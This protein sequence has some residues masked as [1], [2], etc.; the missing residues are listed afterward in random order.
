MNFTPAQLS[1]VATLLSDID[2]SLTVSDYDGIGPIA[3]KLADIEVSD[4]AGYVLGTIKQSPTGV[5]F[6]PNTAPQPLGIKID[7]N[8][9]KKIQNIKGVRQITNEGLKEAKD[10]VDVGGII[11]IPTE[12]L[13][14]PVHKA[15]SIMVDECAA[16]DA[17]AYTGS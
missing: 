2:A 14:C 1:Q 17:W 11:F 5:V 10:R 7:L 12:A 13:N 16:Y 3:I 8:P 15:I 6:S 4:L 9:S